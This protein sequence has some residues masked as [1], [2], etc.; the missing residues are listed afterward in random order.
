VHLI[1][2][3]AYERDGSMCHAIACVADTVYALYVPCHASSQ[4][5]FS[6]SRTISEYGLARSA[7]IC[8]SCTSAECRTW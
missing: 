1:V 5:L 3:H 8:C 6:A 4:S 7:N 2:V